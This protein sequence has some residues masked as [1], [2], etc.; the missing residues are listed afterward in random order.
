[1]NRRCGVGGLSVYQPANHQKAARRDHQQPNL[2]AVSA[3]RDFNGD[4]QSGSATA[5]H[6]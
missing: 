4:H 3:L 1:M 2:S 6:R 5:G